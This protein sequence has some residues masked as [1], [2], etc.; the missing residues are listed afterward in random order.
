MFRVVFS[1]MLVALVVLPACGGGGGSEGGAINGQIGWA[2]T[3]QQFTEINYFSGFDGQNSFKVPLGFI[4]EGQLDVQVQNPGVARFLTTLPIGNDERL[5]AGAF[6]QAVIL[7]TTGAGQTVVTGTLDGQ[8]FQAR[9]NVAQHAP[10]DVLAGQQA[11]QQFCSRCHQGLGKHSTALLA[12]L[13]DEEIFATALRG[14]AIQARRLD[15]TPTTYAPDLAKHGFPGGAH[16]FPE[17]E[18][19]A[20]QIVRYLRSREPTTDLPRE[21]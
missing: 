2:S 8:P 17:A 14:Q 21:F 3:R 20:P 15:G 19:A 18:A 7:E 12:D 1:S 10:A 16:M 4:G 6:L 9:L 5:P 13:T 11:Y